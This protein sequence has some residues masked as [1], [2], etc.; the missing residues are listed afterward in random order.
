M[1]TNLN[2]YENKSYFMR[3]ALQQARK[4]LGKTNE[5]PSV[6]C[7]ISKNNNVISVG[8]TS[9]KGRP[10]AEYNAIYN[11]KLNLRG[12][13]LFSTLEPCSHY[14]KTSPCTNPII[15]EELKEFFLLFMIPIS[16]LLK[17]VQNY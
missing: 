10:H 11:S 3:L 5:N 8:C 14:G 17:K 4:N 2:K 13:D 9:Y 16:D 7:V 12:A 15:K 6:G 1:S